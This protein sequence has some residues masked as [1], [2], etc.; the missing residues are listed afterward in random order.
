MHCAHTARCACRWHGPLRPHH[1]IPQ[2]S[3]RVGVHGRTMLDA[4]ATSS[5]TAI[6]GGSWE[7]RGGQMA[8]GVGALQWVSCTGARRDRATNSPCGK[9][10]AAL[11]LHCHGAFRWL[12]CSRHPVTAPP[13]PPS[14]SQQLR[15]AA[16]LLLGSPHERAQLVDLQRLGRHDMRA[17][18]C[19]LERI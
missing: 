15:H 13:S 2:P 3:G 16:R 17:T 9:E 5:S 1:A 8:G 18:E 11:T 4:S 6:S 7:L 12:P 10:S 19:V 14:H